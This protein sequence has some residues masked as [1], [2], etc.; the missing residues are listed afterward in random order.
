MIDKFDFLVRFWQLKARH[1]QTNAPLSADEQVELLSLLSLVAGDLEVPERGSTK[2]HMSSFP[3]QIIGEGVIVQGELRGLSAAHLLVSC[4]SGMDAGTRVVVRATDAV[5]GK[6]TIVPCIVTWTRP[7]SPDT[8]ALIPD[9][10]PAQG[11]LKGSLSAR[12]SF[13][14]GGHEKLV[15]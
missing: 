10:V 12:C 8:M 3:V 14:F 1:L 15:A 13:P 11:E 5:M 7:G 6:E 2:R 4:L 9:G